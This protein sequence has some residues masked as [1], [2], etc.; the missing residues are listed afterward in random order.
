M[1]NKSTN[2]RSRVINRQNLVAAG[3]GF[4]AGAAAKSIAIEVFAHQE[5]SHHT[6]KTRPWV[7]R[8][9]RIVLSAY[10]LSANKFALRH[11]KHH[12]AECIEGKNTLAQTISATFESSGTN[13]PM[14][15]PSDPDARHWSQDESFDDPMVIIDG[16][17]KKVLRENPWYERMAAKGGLSGAVIPAMG[18]MALYTTA[19]LAGAKKPAIS[20]SSFVAASLISMG[21][22][23]A[24]TAFAETKAGISDGRIN[25][26]SL[27][28]PLRCMVERHDRHHERPDRYDLGITP[29][30]RL[31]IAIGKA[32]GQIEEITENTQS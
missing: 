5:L 31:V 26:S 8:F 20:A 24:I 19:R 23:P 12:R 22:Q 32:T 16:A 9:S 3:L 28:Q 27:G 1:K 18:F 13:E 11:R 25:T 15:E 21:L 14:T 4:V 17:G 10:G 7:K 29:V 6:L 2:E 30:D